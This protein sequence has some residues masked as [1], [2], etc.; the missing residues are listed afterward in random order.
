MRLLCSHAKQIV[1]RQ[2][3]CSK[4]QLD[5]DALPPLVDDIM[6]MAEGFPLACDVGTV[7]YCFR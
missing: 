4:L 6:R 3:A 5:S 2:L 1:V 7:V